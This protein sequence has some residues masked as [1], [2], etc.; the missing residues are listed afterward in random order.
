MLCPTPSALSAEDWVSHPLGSEA[1]CLK[2]I[3]KVLSATSSVNAPGA[4]LGCGKDWWTALW[5]APGF[6]SLLLGKGVTILSQLLFHSPRQSLV[7]WLWVEHS[8]KQV[9]KKL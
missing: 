5:T 6:W 1:R 7:Y 9:A 8:G 4:D 2:N 3:E